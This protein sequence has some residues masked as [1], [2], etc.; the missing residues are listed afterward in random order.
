MF[1]RRTGT[2]LTQVR[3]CSYSISPLDET[4]SILDNCNPLQ[5]W[6]PQNDGMFTSAFQSSGDYDRRK[7]EVLFEAA[8]S[9]LFQAIWCVLKKG[10]WNTAGQ[11]R[12]VSRPITATPNFSWPL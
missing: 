2:S 5:P 8:K 6:F 12:M 4:E 1:R 3:F 11:G 9:V 7:D 10:V